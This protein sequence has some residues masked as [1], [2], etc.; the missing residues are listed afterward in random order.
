MLSRG[1]YFC[2]SYWLCLSSADIE[3]KTRKDL[4]SFVA[5]WA[6]C[7]SCSS[8]MFYDVQERD[9]GWGAWRNDE[10]QQSWRD[11]HRRWR[12]HRRGRASWRFLTRLF[13]VFCFYISQRSCAV[14]H[15]GSVRLLAWRPHQYIDYDREVSSTANDGGRVR[16]LIGSGCAKWNAWFG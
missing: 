9:N 1:E 2:R 10:D 16:I 5:D 14:H 12:K 3:S 7:D 11:Q 15:N 4:T 6:T 13:F 8:A